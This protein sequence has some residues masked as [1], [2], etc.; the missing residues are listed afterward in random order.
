MGEERL[1]AREA[2]LLL[3]G[4]RPPPG[5]HVKVDATERALLPAVADEHSE[6]VTL[7]AER[8]PDSV[9]NVATRQ[10]RVI[11]AS[12]HGGRVVDKIRA[13]IVSQTTF[14]QV[15]PEGLVRWSTR[16]LK[17]VDFVKAPSRTYPDTYLFAMRYLVSVMNDRD[18]LAIHGTSCQVV[19]V[20]KG[21]EWDEPTVVC[22]P[23]KLD[24]A[25]RS[26]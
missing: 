26:S 24:R 7:V 23:V 17:L 5:R 6:E 19:V 8:T 18:P 4:P 11:V 22:E 13:K 21:G 2:T 14:A 25:D 9:A 16:T 1:K 10:Y 3:G 15:G 12:D 20:Y